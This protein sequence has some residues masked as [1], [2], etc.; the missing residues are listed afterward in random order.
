LWR[1]NGDEM[2]NRFAD[3]KK[4]VPNR[5]GVDIEDREGTLDG[6]IRI[7]TYKEVGTNIFVDLFDSAVKDANKAHLKSEV[8]PWTDEGADKATRFLQKHGFPVVVMLK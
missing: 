2:S 7:E 4:V 1:L 8:F 5:W 6:H 3:Y